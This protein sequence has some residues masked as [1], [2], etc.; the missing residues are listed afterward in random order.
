MDIETAKMLVGAALI[1]AIG[2]FTL[3]TVG[4]T[5]RDMLTDLRAGRA[6]RARASTAD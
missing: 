2:S 3:L 6:E 1:V 5:V 4:W